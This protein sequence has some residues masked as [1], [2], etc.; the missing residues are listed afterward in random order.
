MRPTSKDGELAFGLRGIPTFCNSCHGCYGCDSWHSWTCALA[1]SQTP[2]A[3]ASLLALCCGAF[4]ARVK[5]VAD[6]C[7]PSPHTA[8]RVAKSG[9]TRP[10]Q[11]ITLFR[12][13]PALL[14]PPSGVEIPRRTITGGLRS[15]PVVGQ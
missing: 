11:A 6:S 15:A 7:K 1:V 5:S 9:E 8:R 4:H 3:A 10:Q 12:R 2:H 13:V 14:R